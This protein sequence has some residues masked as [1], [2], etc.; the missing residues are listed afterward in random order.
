MKKIK[1][2]CI[3]LFMNFSLQSYCQDS[4]HY[5][6][7]TGELHGLVPEYKAAVDIKT[8]KNR[9]TIYNGYNH[10]YTVL[11]SMNQQDWYQIGMPN[12]QYALFN[13]KKF[14][15]KI[16]SADSTAFVSEVDVG[17]IY[18]LEFNSTL[19]KWQIVMKQQIK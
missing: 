3:L 13:I 4:I 19:K 17:C 8:L 10:S 9:I 6:V 11:V 15:A 18:G 14:Y 16:F 12:M 7:P 1:F 5:S 2:F